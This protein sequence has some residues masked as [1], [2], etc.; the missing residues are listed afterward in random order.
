MGAPVIEPG[1]YNMISQSF[2]PRS[3]EF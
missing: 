2:A 3:K 1:S